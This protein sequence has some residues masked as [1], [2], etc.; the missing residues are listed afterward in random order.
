MDQ[1]NEGQ[2]IQVIRGTNEVIQW[3]NCAIHWISRM[4][5]AF[6]ATPRRLSVQRIS[7]LSCYQGEYT[8]FRSGSRDRLRTIL[9]SLPG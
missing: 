5:T 9:L 2:R 6:W 1:S 8:F 3:I 4:Q 7:T